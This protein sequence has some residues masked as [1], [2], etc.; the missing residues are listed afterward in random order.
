MS[1]RK[2]NPDN[3]FQDVLW[4][5]K[6]ISGLLSKPVRFFQDDAVPFLNRPE[7]AF[8]SSRPPSNTILPPKQPIRPKSVP[9]T[10]LSFS[11]ASM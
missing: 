4:K 6:F 9:P 3:L 5:C 10:L 7:I 8:P 1:G 11:F 2:S